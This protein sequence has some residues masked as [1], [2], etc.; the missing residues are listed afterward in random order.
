MKPKLVTVH[1][2]VLETVSRRISRTVR[3]SDVNHIDWFVR[4]FSGS[5][6]TVTFW[7]ENPWLAGSRYS[8]FQPHGNPR[9]DFLGGV[10][11]SDLIDTDAHAYLLAYFRARHEVTSTI[12]LGTLEPHPIPSEFT[13]QNIRAMRNTP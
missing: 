1:N 5:T 9:A 3:L 10:T 4:P 7:T 6:L 12:D 11:E 8:A 13:P 2:G